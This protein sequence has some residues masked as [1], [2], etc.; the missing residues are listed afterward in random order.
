ME[1]ISHAFLLLFVLITDRCFD[2]LIVVYD[3]CFKVCHLYFYFARE[4]ISKQMNKVLSL[5]FFPCVFIHF[6]AWTSFFF[7][8]LFTGYFF[9]FFFFGHTFFFDTFSIDI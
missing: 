2:V 8:F 5:S 6:T 1:G 9:F 7:S 3:C 4:K